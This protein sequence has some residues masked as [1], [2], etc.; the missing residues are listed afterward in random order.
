MFESNEGYRPSPI[1]IVLISV[2]IR[3]L[4]EQAAMTEW[5]FAQE[6]WFILVLILWHGNRLKF[7]YNLLC[8]K[9]FWH[10]SQCHLAVRRLVKWCFHTLELT[11]MNW[12]W[13]QVSFEEFLRKK[14]IS[15]LNNYRSGDSDHQQRFRGSRLVERSSQW[16]SWSLSRQLCQ[17]CQE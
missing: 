1:V 9:Y 17:T 10:L 8:N 15:R 14:L 6:K 3:M 13:Y 2:R 12:T 4:S 5:V 11:M 16:K 7:L